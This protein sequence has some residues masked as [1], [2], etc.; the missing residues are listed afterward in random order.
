[1]RERL[2]LLMAAVPAILAADNLAGRA[3]EDHSSRP[4]AS[5]ELRVY[6]VGQRLLAAELET[7]LEGRFTAVGL[8]PGEYRIE[9]VKANYIAATVRRSSLSEKLTI[10]LVH[11]GV[12]SGAVLDADG[13]PVRGAAVY[14][15]PKP[16]GGGPL[17]ALTTAGRN[18][19]SMVNERGQYRIINL[20]PGE[21]GVAVAYGAPTAIFGSTGGASPHR[22]VGSGVQFYPA[23]SRPQIFS[24]AGGEECRNVDFALQPGARYSISGKLELSAPK[25]RFWLALTTGDQPSLANA[26]AETDENGGFRFD[27]VAS[28][29]C[30][31]D[32]PRPYVAPPGNLAQAGR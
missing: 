8:A 16:A 23:N 18:S 22:T 12:I 29:N 3:V 19:Y 2:L 7:D 15:M 11:C 14:A 5:V 10:R 26:V 24:V 6:R 32:R 21:Y 31:G 4:L 17:R 28:G 27:G 13:K 30:H 9:A 1:M 25:T 20:P